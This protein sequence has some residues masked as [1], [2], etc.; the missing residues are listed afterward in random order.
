[1]ALASR[2]SAGFMNRHIVIGTRSSALAVTQ[3]TYVQ[4]LLRKKNPKLSVHLKM[5]TTEG[6]RKTEQALWQMEGKDFWVKELDQALVTGKVDLTV[7]S[8]KDLSL[9]RPDGMTLA[10]IPS[11]EDPRDVLF[12]NSSLLNKGAH[13]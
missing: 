11:R 3:A 7:H 1:M 6:D 2:N 10:A 13:V 12:L 8:L 9:S 4:N 5:F